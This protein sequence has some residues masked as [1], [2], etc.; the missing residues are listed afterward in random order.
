MKHRGLDQSRSSDTPRKFLWKRLLNLTQASSIPKYPSLQTTSAHGHIMLYRNTQSCSNKSE[1][2]PKC[3]HKELFKLP[4]RFKSRGFPCKGTKVLRTNIEKQSQS[5]M[6][7][8]LNL[9]FCAIESVEKEFS[10]Q[11]P[12]SLFPPPNYR[13]IPW[14]VTP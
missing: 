10:K 7:P 5:T 13:N 4:N 8:A 14:F 2:A 1:H 3:S 12:Y 11:F 6:V 9:M